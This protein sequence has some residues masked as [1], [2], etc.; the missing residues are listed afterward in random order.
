MG[1]SLAGLALAFVMFYLVY[2]L[3]VPWVLYSGRFAGFWQAR[4]EAS[5]QSYQAYVSEQNLSVEQVVG[6]QDQGWTDPSTTF[7]AVVI[8]VEPEAAEL[9]EANLET[10]EDAAVQ[11]AVTAAAESAPASLFLTVS[12]L[13]MIQCADGTVYLSAAPNAMWVDGLG[14]ALGLVLALAGFCAVM[15][16]AV[17]RLLRRIE[18]LSRE[19]ELL[20]AGD[21]GHSIHAPGSDELSSLG[22]NIER[23]RLSV[24]ERIEG[25]REAVGANSRL[26]TGLSHDLRTPLTKLTGYLEILIYRKYG[27]E[28]EQEA[29][30]RMAAEKA[31]Q[32][33]GLTDQ[34]FDRCQAS[35]QPEGFAGPP[36][37]VDGAALLGQILSEQCCDLQREGFSVQPP[38]FGEEFTLYLRVEDTVRVFDNLF[39]NLRKYADPAFPV[40]IRAEIGEEAVRLELANRILAESAGRDSHGCG[41]PTMKELMGRG[42]GALE[43]EKEGETY[44][45]VL[46]FPKCKNL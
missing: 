39:S 41:L 3:A 35:G 42:G 18:E 27:T 19:T 29:F 45:T 44:R 2:G 28:A 26:I 23:L 10:P 43:T 40:D 15:V 9:K 31:A 21:L 12:D 7:Y 20:M 5:L 46:L 36:E 6:G 16:P 8:G 37:A 34:L 25:E 14:R 22:E 13:Q 4:Q 38:V 33:K 32:I 30:L 24:L 17:V 1:A 11:Y